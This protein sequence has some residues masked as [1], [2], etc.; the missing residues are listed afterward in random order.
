MIIFQ[1][2]DLF[3]VPVIKT[4][5]QTLD[6]EVVTVLRWGMEKVESISGDD[7]KVYLLDL[8]SV[9]VEEIQSLAGSIRE[10]FPAARLAA[11]APHVQERRL[12][13][14]QAAGFDA[15]VSRGQLNSRAAELLAQLSR[16]PLK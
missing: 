12:A 14:A 15:V 7:V 10:R 5:A 2:K 11:Y 1:T 9:T 4:A 6:W 16:S 3:F 8:S 13:T